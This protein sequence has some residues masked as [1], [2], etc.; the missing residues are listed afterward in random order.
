[1]K[2]S[3]PRLPILNKEDIRVKFKKHIIVR[4]NAMNGGKTLGGLWNVENII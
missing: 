1:M 2:K 4:C 3:Y